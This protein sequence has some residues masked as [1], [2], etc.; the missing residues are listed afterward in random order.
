MISSGQTNIKVTKQS[1]KPRIFWQSFISLLTKTLPRIREIAML[2]F[3]TQI[4]DKTEL[5]K[6]PKTGRKYENSH[7]LLRSVKL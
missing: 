6:K 4:K 1:I 3:P 2:M 5:P 7:H